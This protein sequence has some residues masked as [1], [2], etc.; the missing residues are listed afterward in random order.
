MGCHKKL[1]AQE[2]HKPRREDL[3]LHHRPRIERA[4]RAPG[5]SKPDPNCGVRRHIRLRVAVRCQGDIVFSVFSRR[6]RMRLRR[7]RCC[8]C[9]CTRL[10]ARHSPAATQAQQVSGTA[11]VCLR[12]SCHRPLHARRLCLCLRICPWSCNEASLTALR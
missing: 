11:H 2:L 12:R 10:A 8:A 7:T 5:M 3:K 1:V 6:G 4:M 9:V